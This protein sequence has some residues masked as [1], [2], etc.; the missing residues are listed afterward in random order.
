ML[1]LGVKAS[2]VKPPPVFVQH[3]DRVG[4]ELPEETSSGFPAR[5]PMRVA[6]LF[7][8]PAK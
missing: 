5:D 4:S 6:A 1:S 2:S 8:L 7:G 3:P